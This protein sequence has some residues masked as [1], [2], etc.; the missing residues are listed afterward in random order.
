MSDVDPLP[1]RDPWSTALP[2]WEHRILTGR[3]LVPELPLFASEAE[4][5]LR[6]FKRLRIPDVIGQP[7]M[8]EAC[9]EWFFPI[10]AAIFGS[11]DPETHKRM[12]QEYFLLIPKKNSK[13]SNGGA[14]MLTAA[15]MNRRP[16]AEF[17][18]IAPTM[19]V[20]NIAFKQAVGTIKL[21]SELDK[22]F[23]VQ[24][25]LRTITHRITGATL[26]IKA[27]DTDVITGG[28]AVG[29]MVDET[30]VFSK[31]ANAADIFLELRGGLTAR[32]DGFF[33]QTTTQSKEP[34]AGVFK[35]ELEKARDVRDGKLEFPLLPVLYEFPNRVLDSGEWKQRRFWKVVNPNIGKSVA[36][37]YLARELMTA[38]RE[39]LDKL[40]L[41]A[42]QHMNVEIGLRLRSDRWRG[43]DFWEAAV[44]RALTLD[45]LLSRS[46][47]CTIGI[48]GGGLDD[49][50][51]MAVL[52]RDSE[53]VGGLG[54]RQPDRRH[55]RVAAADGLSHR[56][57][58]YAD[59][60]E[61]SSALSRAARQPELPTRRRS[62]S[63]S[64]WRLARAVGQR[65]CP[66]DPARHDGSVV[67]WC[68][69]G[70]TSVWCAAWAAARSNIAG[71]RTAR[72]MSRPTRPCCTS[73]ASA[74]IRS[75][76]CRRCIS[77]ARL[78][79]GAGDRQ[80]RRR[81]VRNGLRPSGVLTFDKFLTAEQRDV[82]RKER[83]ATKFIGAMNA[84]RPLVL[85]GGTKWEQL[86]INPEDAQMLES[87]GFSVEEICRFFGVPPFM[88]GHTEK[89][90][91]WGTGLE[92]QTLGFQKFTLRRRLK[93]IE[94]A[95]EKQLLTPGSSG[96][97][98]RS[99]STSRACCAATAPAAPSS[100]RP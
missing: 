51:G 77:A 83:L 15:I 53:P 46:D 35:S 7:T 40:T 44:D 12:I 84:G 3:T 23:Q 19:L 9:G 93:R 2:D 59:G 65:L 20:A 76:A 99:S 85:E 56:R 69:S 78:R 66:Q 16:E 27:A 70:P 39:G 89:S 37:D 45:E 98:S 79:P 90:T 43:A 29:T 17:Q 34:P 61:G 14:V 36:E 22:V 28:K 54:L 94:Q 63:G 52:G 33:F 5:A 50:L 47:V 71:P 60:G 64:S 6:I 73:A 62:T 91:S 55:D 95:L 92:Q 88:I 72:P 57:R 1:W 86:T 21:D 42:S 48:D 18:F 74:A 97:A 75:A 24:R 82:A 32:P 68:R 26:Q 30:H 31:K 41:F 81:D 4:R 96:S 87:R 100:T 80:G 25:H 67:G 58:R 38:E 11:Y 10:V 49:L 8:A 13:S